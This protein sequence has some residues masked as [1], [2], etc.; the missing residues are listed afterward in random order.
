LKQLQDIETARREQY[1]KSQ[2]PILKE[3]L[4][5]IKECVP[6]QM[7]EELEKSYTNAFTR[8]EAAA[9]TSFVVA[10]AKVMAQQKEENIKLSKTLDDM[11]AK[12]K[13]LEEQQPIV[14]AHAK[15]NQLRLGLVTGQEEPEVKK[16]VSVA[17]S[18]QSPQM[19]DLFQPSQE[20]R[21]LYEM[22][23][24]KQPELNVTASG[25]GGPASDIPQAF[26]HPYVNAFPHSMRN[27][28]GASKVFDLLCA[29]NFDV[30]PNKIVVNKTDRIDD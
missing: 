17:A 18:S 1:A 28:K 27:L 15:A 7:P 26:R 3:Y 25:N 16:E 13:K 4:S 5:T 19:F 2:E 12:I 8:P 11:M 22:T 21:I 24:G 23:T 14:N 10:Q 29:R 6:V 20:E 9:T 30:I